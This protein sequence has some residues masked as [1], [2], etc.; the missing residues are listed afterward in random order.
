MRNW[1]S[2]GF[3]A[4]RSL[5]RRVFYQVTS[6]LARIQTRFAGVKLGREIRFYGLP[7]FQKASTG[8]ISIGKH[9]R[10]RSKP[11]SNLIG[12]N[13]PCIISAHAGA[14]LRIG[15]HCGFSG[16]VIGCFNSITIEDNVRFGANTLVTDG[17]WHPDDS[18]SGTSK[19]IHIGK[20]A[21]IGV[22]A[23]ILKGVTIGENAVIGAGSVVCSDIPSNSVA[24]GNPC[25]VIK[26][27]P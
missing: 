19:P 5:R 23:I 15:D 14:V 18:R 3:N 1:I 20:N 11:T 17:D 6:W 2:K 16:T 27:I 24:A 21:W 9:C 10:F 22:N 7:Y 13:R 8:Q 12:I 25:R 26:T 4:Q